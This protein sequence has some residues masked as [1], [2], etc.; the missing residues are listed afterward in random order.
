MYENM[1][2]GGETL[3]D[4][5]RQSYRATVA[6]I[7][8]TEDLIDTKQN[9]LDTIRNGVSTLQRETEQ[10]QERAAA[11][12]NLSR[13]MKNIPKSI[14][15]KI[16][17]TGII[18]TT[19]GV[20]EL[21]EKYD[22][23]DK[24]QIKTLISESGADTTVK[25]VLK[26]IEE[27]NNLDKQRPRPKIDADTSDFDDDFRSMQGDIST[28]VNKNHVVTVT[29]NTG[30]AIGAVAAL[31]RELNGLEDEVVY[32][33][34]VRRNRV[35]G[36]DQE[37]ASG[38]I[39]SGRQRIIAGEAGAEAIVPLNRSLAQVDPAVRWLSA[40]AQGFQPTGTAGRSVDVGGIQIITPT[41]DPHAV[42]QEAINALTGAL[43]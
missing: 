23:L 29:A 31:D 26:L 8:A 10:T 41:E 20:A 13:D 16:K 9:N 37:F 17:E 3:T 34:Y 5:Q 21:A 24:R 40:I 11:I 4:A 33:D 32:V 43:L 19:K 25:K 12:R 36:G 15:T 14:E 2:R 42:A 28:L 35:S 30:A 38:G 27:S 6:E 39:V 18:P 22:L 7:E 1:I